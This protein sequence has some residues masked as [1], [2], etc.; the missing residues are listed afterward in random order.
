MRT[1]EYILKLMSEHDLSEVELKEGDQR[2]RLRKG[3]SDSGLLHAGAGT[4]PAP[5]SPGTSAALSTNSTS[6]APAV[7]TRSSPRSNRRW[8]VRFTPSRS[9]TSPI[10]SLWV[11]G[12]AKTVV[13][14]VEAM[15][16]FNEIAAEVSGTI[17]EVCVKNGDPVEYNQVLFR[18]DP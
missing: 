5:R 18:V 16:L 12:D 7:P 1:V 8:S 15:K 9:R 11:Q 3:R 10:T 13:C 14:Q 17:A 2:I 4:L 6:A